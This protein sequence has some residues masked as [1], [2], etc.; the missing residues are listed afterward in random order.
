MLRYSGLAW[1]ECQ[2]I[3]PTGDS[4]MPRMQDYLELLSCQRNVIGVLGF[5]DARLLVYIGLDTMRL[6][7]MSASHCT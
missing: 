4:S 2:P 5:E 1:R 3:R 7:L 6:Y